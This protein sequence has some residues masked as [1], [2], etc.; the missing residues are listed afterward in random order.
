M[1]YGY[2]RVSTKEQNVD[3]QLTAMYQEGIA[4]KQL[5][6]DK[7]SGKDFN[8]TAYKRMLRRLKKGDEIVI[9]SI[10]RLGRNYD[11]ILEQWRYLV[12]ERE[13]DIQV[14]ELDLLN[15]KS[16]FD[17]NITGRFI[18]DLVLQIL[19]YV[20]QVERENMLQRQREGIREAK[21]K[22]VRFGR[23]IKRRPENFEQVMQQLEKSEITIQVA[24]NKLG[25][26]KSTC[27][28]WLKARKAGIS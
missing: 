7:M 4:T 1:K 28:R 2:I 19:S 18:S 16:P 3:R 22:G 12:R 10:D 9:K 17:N 6:I 24:S 11:E 5:Y 14:L 8:R 23:P 27:Y 25:I 13:V 15:T 20:A 26:S 21:K